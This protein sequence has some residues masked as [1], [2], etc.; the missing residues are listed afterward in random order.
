MKASSNNQ[1]EGKMNRQYMR[2]CDQLEDLP[3]GGQEEGEEL[4]VLS[5]EAAAIASSHLLQ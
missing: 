1:K 4:V 5:V 2:I 3:L